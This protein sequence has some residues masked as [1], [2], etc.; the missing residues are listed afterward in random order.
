MSFQHPQVDKEKFSE[1]LFLKLG[2]LLGLLV[3]L[4]SG[5]LLTAFNWF[6][7]GVFGFLFINSFGEKPV[8]RLLRPA[9]SILF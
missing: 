2:S 3:L 5:D 6:G 1:I 4:W 8:L 9:F 7:N